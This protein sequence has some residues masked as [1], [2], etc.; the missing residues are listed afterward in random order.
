M[1]LEVGLRKSDIWGG[2][3]RYSG[4]DVPQ[5]MDHFVDILAV[6]LICIMKVISRISRILDCGKEKGRGIAFGRRCYEI[7]GI[8]KHSI[9]RR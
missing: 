9:E 3:T 2:S 4:F 5:Q 1:Q 7:G 6:K 8:V